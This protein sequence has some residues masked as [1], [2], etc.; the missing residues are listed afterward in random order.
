MAGGAGVAGYAL[1]VFVSEVVAT[2]HAHWLARR[3]WAD[4]ATAPVVRDAGATAR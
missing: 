1:G 2:A 3:A 4:P